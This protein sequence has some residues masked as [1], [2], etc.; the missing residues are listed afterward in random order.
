MNAE[1][2]PIRFGRL[3]WLL[4]AIGLTPSRAYL[5]VGPDLVSVHMSWCFHADVPRASIRSVSQVKNP[6]PGSFGAHGWRGRWLI[7]GAAG[8]LVAVEIEP[9]VRA[10]TVKIPVRLCQ[11]LVSVDDPDEVVA[12]LSQG[13]R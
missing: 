10:H 11:L 12:K 6:Y 8:P 7:N 3:K 13:R 5:D 1:R 4:I 2:I 9:P